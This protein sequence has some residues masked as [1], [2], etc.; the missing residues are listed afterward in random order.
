MGAQLIAKNIAV[1][2]GAGILI[3]YGAAKTSDPDWLSKL[4]LI[5]SWSGV[6]DFLALALPWFEIVLGIMIL[7]EGGM[8]RGARVASGLLLL[9]FLPFLFYF[10]LAGMADCGCGGGGGV[11]AHPA[12]G[13]F[14]NII[15]AVGLFWG[16]NI[17]IWPHACFDTAAGQQHNLKK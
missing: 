16:R 11:L 2:A 10:L 9:F 15:L 14:R 4:G 17:S 5:T 3:F 12:V 6:M 8:A 7:G 13:I 1:W